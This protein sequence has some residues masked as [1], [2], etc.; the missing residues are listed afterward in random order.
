MSEKIT[1]GGADDKHEAA[2]HMA[3]AA[4]RAEAAGD[5]EQAAA[6]LD[7]A[8]KADPDAV[9]EAVSEHAG[10]AIPT[11]DDE[12]EL[13]T[14]SENVVP[15]SDAPSRSGITGSGSGADNQGL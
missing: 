7:Q 14:A 1:Q 2:R 9:V 8:Q 3:E 15:G 5:V 11:A 13:E 6:L 4:M 10:D 12:T